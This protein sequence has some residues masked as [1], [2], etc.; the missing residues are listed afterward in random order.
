MVCSVPVQINL[1]QNVTSG[2]L[3]KETHFAY[4]HAYEI[5]AT[6]VSPMLHSKKLSYEEMYIA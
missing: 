5:N 4:V 3:I 1:K 2:Q 6:L